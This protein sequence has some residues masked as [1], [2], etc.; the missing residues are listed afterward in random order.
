MMKQKLTLLL[1]ILI[2]TIGN[3]QN[4]WVKGSLIL[5]SDFS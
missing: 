4:N 5:K 1:L 3:A 2:I